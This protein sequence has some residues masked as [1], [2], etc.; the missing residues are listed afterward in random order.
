MSS[1]LKNL[2]DAVDNGE[3][4][5]DAAKKINEIDM[6]ADTTITTKKSDKIEIK[7]VSDE[8]VALIN[9]EYEKQMENIRIIDEIN[10]KIKTLI[11][12]DEM[13]LN[14]VIDMNTFI[15]EIKNK[16]S[17]EFDGNDTRFTKLQEKIN[18]LNS[19]YGSIINN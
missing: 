5:S 16:F 17:A 6:L 14:S 4:N 10:N 15:L 11:D 18:E 12:I 2:K 3:F 9:S 1:F 19:K 7:T 13:I 8:E